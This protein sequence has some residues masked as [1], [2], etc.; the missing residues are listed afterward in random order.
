MAILGTEQSGH[1]VE[2]A[3]MG[4]MGC[5]MTIWGG[6]QYDLWAKFMITVSHN[7]NPIVNIIYWENTKET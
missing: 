1:C 4:R 5:N 3:V 7:D 2:V 6:V